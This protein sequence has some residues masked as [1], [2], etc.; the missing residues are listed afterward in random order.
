[1]DKIYI[2]PADSKLRESVEKNKQEIRDRTIEKRDKCNWDEKKEKAFED[3]IAAEAEEKA[4]EVFE[5]KGM[6][7]NSKTV[8][9]NAER[10]S[11]K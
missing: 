8:A 2:Y 11:R 4:R 3:R 5:R 7:A 1:M 6:I 9:D 10:R